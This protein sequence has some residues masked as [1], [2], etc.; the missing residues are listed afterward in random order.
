MTNLPIETDWAGVWPLVGGHLGGGFRQISLMAF[1]WGEAWNRRDPLRGLRG[2][3]LSC[4]KE[5]R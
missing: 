3:D 4:R 1:L 2:T 5:I